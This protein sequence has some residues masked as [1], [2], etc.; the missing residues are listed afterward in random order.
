V[1]PLLIMMGRDGACHS[2]PDTLIGWGYTVAVPSVIQPVT[3]RSDAQH[4]AFNAAWR[5]C[6]DRFKCT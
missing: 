6:I 4:A 2:P 1:K 5:G 3:V